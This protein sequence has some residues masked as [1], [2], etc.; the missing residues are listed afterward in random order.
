MCFFLFVAEN[1]NTEIGDLCKKYN[2]DYD[3]LFFITVNM[4]QLC[5][6][7]KLNNEN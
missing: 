5:T 2:I 1:L 6:K 4:F 3:G 7:D